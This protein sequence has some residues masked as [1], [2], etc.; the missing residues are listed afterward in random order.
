LSG[1]N[2]MYGS[3]EL[4]VGYRFGSS[5]F[6][7]KKIAARLYGSVVSD[8]ERGLYARALSGLEKVRQL[9]PDDS[10]YE[11]VQ[12][13][14]SL[15]AVYVSDSSGE[16]KDATAIRNGVSKYIIEDDAKECVK[17]LRYAYSLKADN[18][19]LNQMVKA[20]AKE[21]NVV[22]EDAATNWNMAEQKVY[23]AL[24]RIKEKKYYEAVRLCEE[25]LSLEPDNVTAYKRLGSV[26]YLLKD[27]EKARKNWLKAIELAPEDSDIPQIRE[28]LQKIP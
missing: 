25:A 18:E 17:L 22:I 4:T 21:N 20:I 15:V 11:A 13:K 3:H 7:N 19:K 2:E 5:Q 12:V 23:Q 27:M 14:L 16:E 9:S 26:F 6:T 8:I 24:E 1:L 10:V 28:I